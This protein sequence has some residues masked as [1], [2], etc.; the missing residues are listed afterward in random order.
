MRGGCSRIRSRPEFSLRC[1]MQYSRLVDLVQVQRRRRFT[2]HLQFMLTLRRE[3]ARAFYSCSS[4]LPAP[5]DEALCAA[6]AAASTDLSTTSRLPSTVSTSH[7]NTSH[8]RW[9]PNWIHKHHRPNFDSS[10]Q[11]PSWTANNRT[12]SHSLVRSLAPT[13]V[14]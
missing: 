5:H 6:P 14:W 13:L 4:Q 10:P 2:P 9:E 12:R 11:P 3:R 1:H 7:F 8:A